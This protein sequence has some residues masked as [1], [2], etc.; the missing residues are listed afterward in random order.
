MVCVGV[1]GEELVLGQLG[2]GEL[3]V[4]CPLDVPEE[5]LDR[6]PVCHARFFEKRARL[7]TVRAMS[8]RV[9]TAGL[10]RDPTAWL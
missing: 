1:G 9:A 10:K 6:L 8:R 3:V 7:P 5:V 2:V 4:E